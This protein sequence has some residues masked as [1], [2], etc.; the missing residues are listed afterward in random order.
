MFNPSHPGEI[1]SDYVH[2]T[3]KT[4]TEIAEG[5]GI[6]RKVL[7]SILNERAG[8]STEMAIKLSVAFNT[9]VEFWINLQK[10]Y[11]IYHSKQKVDTSR[12]TH[13]RDEH[14]AA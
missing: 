11:E 13:Y 6:S 7:S 9:S 3:G 10:Q 5:L 2:S 1:L 14:F 4:I 12:I 8:I